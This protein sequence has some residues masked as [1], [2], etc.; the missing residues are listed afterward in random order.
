MTRVKLCLILAILFH[1]PL[2]HGFETYDVD[3]K[4]DRP[5]NVH[6]LRITVDGCT[7]EF[8]VPNKDFHK[9]SNNGD[10]LTQALDVA[11]ERAE[12]GCL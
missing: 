4:P 6:I 2:V 5:S 8:K 9:F 7:T 11:I 3:W 10:A 12:N 1:R